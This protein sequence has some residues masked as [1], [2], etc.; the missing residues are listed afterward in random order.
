M[1]VTVR[2]N[3]DGEGDSEMENSD[4]DGDDNDDD[5]Q[6]VKRGKFHDIARNIEFKYLPGQGVSK[7]SNDADFAKLIGFEK[8]LH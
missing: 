7:R 2:E 3:S 6:L 8:P 5:D 4:E 1:V